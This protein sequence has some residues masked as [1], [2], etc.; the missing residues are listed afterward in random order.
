MGGI[1]SLSL[2]KAPELPGL[3]KP[4]QQ[5]PGVNKEKPLLAPGQKQMDKNVS[6]Q[7][8]INATLSTSGGIYAMSISV[9]DGIQT[10][11]L[12]PSTAMKVAFGELP[13]AISTAAFTAGDYMVASTWYTYA[14]DNGLSRTLQL[15]TVASGNVFI[16]LY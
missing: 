15:L 4:I 13:A 6:R 5:P 9:P 14:L 10:A 12:Y 11:A 3:K 8:V 1:D 2:P 16:D 7:A